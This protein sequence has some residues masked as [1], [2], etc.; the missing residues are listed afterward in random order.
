MKNVAPQILLTS[1]AHFCYTQERASSAAID[2]A[3]KANCLDS[4]PFSTGGECLSP[5]MNPS[6]AHRTSSSSL[7]PP[8]SS[9]TPAP[10]A[11]SA[12]IPLLRV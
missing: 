4:V 2:S 9:S 12:L 3:N 10:P 6:T 11:Y 5:L 7:A 1:V 8:P